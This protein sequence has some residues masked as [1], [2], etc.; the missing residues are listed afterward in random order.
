[1]TVATLICKIDEQI[2]IRMH[3]NRMTGHIVQHVHV[4]AQCKYLSCIFLLH[5]SISKIV[6]YFSDFFHGISNLGLDFK[7]HNCGNISRIP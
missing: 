6:K 5:P 1:M 7:T 2:D 3:N 4:K